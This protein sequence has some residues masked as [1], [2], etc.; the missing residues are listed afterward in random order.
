MGKMFDAV[1]PKCGGNCTDVWPDRWQC[2]ACKERFENDEVKWR[3]VP[4]WWSDS[5]TSSA[6]SEDSD[7]DSKPLIIEDFYKERNPRIYEETAPTLRGDRHGLMVIDVS[8][9]V[10]TT[11]TPTK[12]TPP[13][14]EKQIT[15]QVTL[16]ESIQQK[17]PTSI[18]FVQDFHAKR[19]RLRA[20][21]R[22]SRTLVERFEDILIF[23]KPAGVPPKR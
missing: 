4:R 5:L 2:L 19:F 20:R 14:S 1:C 13:D 15:T 18:S 9:P 11:D 16:G 6:E 22:V 23:E 17:Y 8:G 10:T 12:S 7:S 3:L 21:G